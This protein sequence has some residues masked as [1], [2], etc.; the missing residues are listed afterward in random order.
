MAVA[1]LQ[2]AEDEN[3]ELK[4]AL[5]KEKQHGQDCEDASLLSKTGLSRPWQAFEQAAPS[6]LP[7]SSYHRHHRRRHH[8]P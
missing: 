8:L 3:Q 2:Y 1:S 4:A 6:F 7:A 5:Q